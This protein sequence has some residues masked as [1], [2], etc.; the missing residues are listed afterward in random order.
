MLDLVTQGVHKLSL[1]FQ[2][3][4]KVYFLRYFHLVCFIGKGNTKGFFSSRVLSEIIRFEIFIYFVI[5]LS[6][7]TSAVKVKL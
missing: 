2:Y 3:F 1:P 4:N 5:K 6:L 7:F